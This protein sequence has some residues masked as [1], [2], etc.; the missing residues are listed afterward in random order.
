MDVTR[1]ALRRTGA[2]P[3]L[4]GWAGWGAH[5]RQK[6][7]AFA[8]DPLGEVKRHLDQLP[9]DYPPAVV[10]VAD[11]MLAVIT[12][13]AVIQRHSYFGT[14]LPFLAAPLAFL[15]IP[16]FFLLGIMPRPAQMVLY[17][18]AS[19]AL[20]LMQPVTADFAPFVLVVAVGEAASIGAKRL[21]VLLAAL[22]IAELLAFDMLGNLAWS[23]DGQR[24]EGAPMY[25]LGVALGWMVGVMMQYQRR[26]LYQ[27]R[28]YQAVRSVQAA[29]EERRRI[30]REVHDVIA[31]SLSVTMLHLTA[32]RHALKT[33]R[34]VDE[35]VDALV[36]AERLGRQAM[37]DIR[38]T[39]GLL[40]AGPSK[41]DAE[42][43][44]EDI[45]DLVAD[46]ARAGLGIEY[47]AT[48]DFGTIS[49]AVGLAL[50][51]IGQESLANIVKH[52]DGA[53]AIVQLT[54]GATEVAL[55]VRNSLP[56]GASDGADSGM[57]LSGMRQR[58]ELLDGEIVAG[59]YDDGWSVRVRIPIVPTR[60]LW[61]CA[62]MIGPMLPREGA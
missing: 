13:C 15:P 6:T 42:P 40:D 5:V 51:R 57:G 1:A 44:V 4:P 7:R 43:G 33:D 41:R 22:A 39:V 25:C 59:P 12:I 34:D 48:G 3:A 10:L 36:D 35:A 55:V 62:P 37:A 14:G 49:A 28:E 27:E 46:F 19:T 32:A 52:A 16:L 31:H 8:R 53:T 58:A 38:R 50:Y 11:I 54:V 23:A 29:D 2:P 60:G 26:F 47:R 9:F 17:A 18:G 61:W 56:L 24:L 30:A 45:A 21:T 20:F